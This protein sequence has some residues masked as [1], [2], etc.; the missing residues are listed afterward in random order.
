[1]DKPKS[2]LRFRDRGAHAARRPPHTR[3]FFAVA[4]GLV[5]MTTLSLATALSFRNHHK[6]AVR[7][8]VPTTYTRIPTASTSTSEPTTTTAITTEPAPPSTT[9]PR[10]STA[11]PRALAPQVT[12]DAQVLANRRAVGL[13]PP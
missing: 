6:P 9:R 12:F 11:T 10:S 7:P 13:P 4:I 5:A 8:T 1:M 3:L 2:E